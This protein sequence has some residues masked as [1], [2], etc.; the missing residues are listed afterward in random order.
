MK[1][2]AYL[3]LPFLLINCTENHPTN[4]IVNTSAHGPNIPIPAV[5]Y[6]NMGDEK[7]YEERR[8]AYFDLIHSNSSNADWRA[9]NTE[10]FNIKAAERAERAKY[11]IVETFAE[12][13]IQGEWRERGSNDV[14][15]NI[16]T[17]DYH[18]LTDD[19][20][21]I[22]DGGILWKG[23]LDGETWTP[24]NDNLQL[25]AEVL[26]AVDLP[27]GGLRIIATV[28]Y[29]VRYSD[30]QGE[31]WTNAT[32]IV[33]SNGSAIDLVELNDADRTIVY[34]YNQVSV[35]DGSS[36]NK[37]AYSTDHGET[38]SVI[39][40]LS[41]GNSRYSSLDAAH[42]SDKAYIFDQ[43]DDLYKFE[44]GALTL[45]AEDLALDGTNRC[46]IQVNEAGG[47]LT[48]YVLLD[49]LHLFKSTDDGTSF[50]FVNDLAT[51]SWDVGIRVSIDDAD[52]LYYGEVNLWRS[53]DG[54][55]SWDLVSEWWEYY[56]D[57]ANKIHADIMDIQ[58]YKTE[59][60]EEFTLVPNHGGLYASYD[61][62]IT[63][64][65]IALQDLNTGQFYDVLT[66]P[67]NASLIFGGT[68]DQG[69]QRT[70]TGLSPDPS[71]FQQVI[72]GDYGEMQFTNNG[73]TIWIQYPGG[74]FQIYPDAESDD[75][76]SHSFNLDGADMPN[77]NWIVP[78][79]SAPHPTDNFIYVGGGNLSGGSGSRLVKLTFTGAEITS[80]QYA[81]DFKTASGAS[82]SA[83]ETTPLNDNFIY[84]VTENGRF[85]RSENTGTSF[86]MTEDYIGPSG[87]WIYTA[88]IYASRLT[89]GL[90]FVGGSGY[91]GAS[92][93]MSVD[94]AKTFIGLDEGMPYTMVHE[95]AMDPSEKFL[96]AATDAG[97]Y[98]YSM[99][100]EEWYDMSGLS[101]PLQQ[102]ISVEFIPSEFIVR[103]ATW[104]RG[105][106]DFNMVNTASVT[107]HA[108]TFSGV[109]IYPNPSASQNVFIEVSETVDLTLFDLRG[110]IILNQKLVAGKQTVDVSNIAN[111]TYIAALRFADGIVKSEKLILQ[112]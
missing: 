61:N 68:Q 6:E 20:Y 69:F 90:V 78:T 16:R 26:Q 95:M 11:R 17:C 28:G 76:Y 57:V 60:G 64:N 22:S 8:E 2:L 74:D 45:I 54:G 101:A 106:W 37:V 75:S 79:G 91:G 47:D 13:M 30:D 21:A 58:P 32:G 73:Q 3:F 36:I 65:N 96:F 23:N 92:V 66:H 82:I 112:K 102:Y 62:L 105:I 38:F 41:T 87:G 104:G 25:G 80:S 49:N 111:G 71:S 24:L 93:Y 84:V 9:I 108:K 40:T 55:V 109:H 31:T 88:D 18:P 34:L 94:S 110:N 4:A 100:T 44:A 29:G 10:N 56:G 85:F 48:L 14:P 107:E 12:G 27:G 97:P 77:Y 52:I 83:I 67:T 39:A 53:Y 5:V 98:V 103:F 86:T 35:M 46:K 1:K 51:G 99:E 7:A 42:G 70:L 15:G 50:A 59:S 72:S 19:V 63:T 33:G 89:P 81:F 43:N